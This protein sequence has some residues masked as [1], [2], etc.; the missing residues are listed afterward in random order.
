[1]IGITDSGHNLLGEQN[2]GAFITL[3]FLGGIETLGT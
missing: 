3:L 2:S 1:M